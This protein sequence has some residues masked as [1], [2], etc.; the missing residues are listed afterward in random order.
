M[1]IAMSG[2][3]RDTGN[4]PVF[5][6]QFLNVSRALR[7]ALGRKTDVLRDDRRAFRTIL[8]DQTQK[9]LP[10]MPGEFNSLSN[11]RELDRLDQ[12]GSARKLDYPAL[13]CF[14]RGRLLRPHFDK[15]GCGLGIESLQVGR[16]FSKRM[17]R[18][19]ERGSNH[20]LD[21]RGAE[22]DET[23]NQGNRFVDRRNRDPCNA[24]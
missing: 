10:D 5:G 13:C 8:A 17:T 14:K 2:M 16:R 18:R 12:L 24:C 15:E 1:K 3:P 9:S 11:A 22:V 4:E 6:K 21:G 20:Q 19:G 23:W 7:Q